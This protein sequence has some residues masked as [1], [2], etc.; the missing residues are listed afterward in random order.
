MKRIFIYLTIQILIFFSG[1]IF[2]MPWEFGMRVLDENSGPT[3]KQI[4]LYQPENLFNPFR[5]V[6]SSA[7]W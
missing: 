3:L 4:R 6:N 7:N 5:E 1:E 2:A